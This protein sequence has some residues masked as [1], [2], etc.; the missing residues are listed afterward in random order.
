MSGNWIDLPGLWGP[1]GVGRRKTFLPFSIHQ[2]PLLLTHT[3]AAGCAR[4]HPHSSARRDPTTRERVKGAGHQ[5]HALPFL[6]RFPSGSRGRTGKQGELSLAFQFWRRPRIFNTRKRANPKRCEGPILPSTSAGGAKHAL[7]AALASAQDCGED[8]QPIRAE[9]APPCLV[10][11]EM[12]RKASRRWETAV[13]CRAL[14]NVRIM[15]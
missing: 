11:P 5:S 4:T 8:D 14:R 12:G 10:R 3:A 6:P 7:Q 1:W 2:F 9:A 13:G 15:L